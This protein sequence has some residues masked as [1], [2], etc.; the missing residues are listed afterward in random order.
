[1]GWWLGLDRVNEW[2][3]S[4]SPAHVRRFIRIA[5]RKQ[6]KRLCVPRNNGLSQR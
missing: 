4:H 3:L 1:M 6:P 2:R 5:H